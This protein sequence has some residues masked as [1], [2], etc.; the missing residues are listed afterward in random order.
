MGFRTSWIARKGSSSEQLLATARREIT[1]ERHDFPDVGWYL[2]ELPGVDNEPWVV[3]IAGGTDN[4]AELNDDMARAIS[5]DDNEVL[6]FWCSDTVMASELVCF[7]DK[8]DV[9]SVSYQS[10]EAQGK[11]K[12]SGDLPEITQTILG[13]LIE[14]QESP[15]DADYIYDLPAALGHALIGFRHDSDPELDDPEPFQVLSKP[16]KTTQPRWRFWRR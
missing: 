9:W 8:S 2:L 12:L 4:F 10:D 1:G 7:K 16:P 13:N 3:L 6:F 15:G 14:Q 11:P 5:S